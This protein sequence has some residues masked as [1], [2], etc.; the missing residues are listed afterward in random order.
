MGQQNQEWEEKTGL[1]SLAPEVAGYGEE[2][3][4]KAMNSIQKNID[5]LYLGFH[6]DI[7]I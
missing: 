4:L 2:T 7:D 3:K 6:S 5:D 1:T